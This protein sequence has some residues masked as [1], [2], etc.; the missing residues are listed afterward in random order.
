MERNE[1]EMLSILRQM[2][3]RKEDC[4]VV[5]YARDCMDLL[6][7]NREKIQQRKQENHAAYEAML[8]SSQVFPTDQ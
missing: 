1:G 2:K 6:E 8:S 7:V 3:E 4:S 5:Q